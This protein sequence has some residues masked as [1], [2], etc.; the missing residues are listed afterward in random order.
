MLWLAA[1]LLSHVFVLIVPPADPPD[2]GTPHLLLHAVR[3]GVREDRTVAVHVQDVGP[4]DGRPDAPVV[5]LVHGSPGSGA[6]LAKLVPA[7][8]QHHRVLV[9]DL[10]GSGLSTVDVP[11]MSIAAHADYLLQ[12]L[13]ALDVPRAHLVGYSMGGGPVLHAA[14]RA[15]ERIASV[16]LVAA[17]GVQELELLG[18]HALNH[19][20][21]VLQLGALWTL[22][23]IV[24]DFGTA[25][26]LDQAVAYARNF[27]ETDQRPLRGIL[28]RLEMPVLVV[29]GPDDF[30]V[31]I[32][33]ARE[34]HRI[35][36]HSEL[37]ES[38]SDHFLVFRTEEARRLSRR[39]GEFVDEVERGEAPRRADAS[40]QRLADAARPFDPSV[41]PPAQGVLL[42]IVWFC[43]AAATL[44]S[45]DLACIGAGLVAATGRIGYVAAASAS[46]TGIFVGDMLLFVAGRLLGRA[47][48]RRAPV[49]WMVTPAALERC[50]RWFERK[51]PAVIVIS[52][53]TP[54]MR[55]PTYLAAGILGTR[56]AWFAL[57]FVLAGLL[58]TPA[59][60]ALA[61]LAGEAAFDVLARVEGHA[62]L[63]LVSLAVALLVVLKLLVPSFTHAGRR[64][65]VGL[66]LRWTRWEFWPMWMVYP[67]I[68]P[69]VA[70]LA[71]RHG[72]LRTVTAVNPGIPG[73]GLVGES[74]DAI[75][76]Q[77]RGAGDALP[78]S[79]LLPGDL[80]S[81]ERM[82]RFDRFVSEH[83]LGWP[84]VLKPDAGQRG[85]GVLLARA[86][87]EV[88]RYLAAAPVETLVQ[89]YVDGVEFGIF[90]HRAPDEPKGHVFA[91]TE[92]VFPDVVGDGRRT[93][94]RLILDDPRGVAMARVYLDNHLDASV[95]VPASGE[96]V[97]LAELG[98]H[99]KGC[100][101]LDGERLATPALVDRID[102]ISKTFPGFHF[103]RYDVRV[104]SAEHLARGESIKVIELNGLTSE[105][106]SIYDPRHSVL[107]AWRTLRAQWRIAFEIGAANVARGVP[108]ARWGELAS[109]ALGFVKSVRK[110][111]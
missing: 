16:T 7:L 90:Y 54:G 8:A 107:F 99:C 18:S 53:F 81:S 55:L 66:W 17:I 12:M 41:V 37:D 108:K 92:K 9:P 96:R 91:I 82:A 21:H 49:K 2:D 24:P 59:L 35:V 44:V 22:R 86:R 52:R 1:L 105:A 5:V 25:R 63:A 101:F 29:H 61:M 42:V 11:D 88:E 97:R 50:T 80:P 43:I 39:I 26:G 94:E 4:D 30:L 79:E 72:G 27:A 76:Q 3:D 45:E 19:A 40:E 31:P 64:R 23:Q 14:E 70:W 28:E 100:I 33:A 77:L 34:H 36:P 95:R 71:L 103:G 20:V 106:T 10:P 65:L 13:D 74:K 75:L 93:L 58:W 6:G 111:A 56:A 98:T 46:F 83:R 110:R 73:G 38:Y 104:P 85:F 48:V 15:P 102:A 51:G 62:L 87:D 68:L 69:Y 84:I 57:W 89:E 47:A 32:E 78:A 60:V 109:L 67:P